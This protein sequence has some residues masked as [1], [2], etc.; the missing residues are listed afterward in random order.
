MC[1][2]ATTCKCAV[3]E[4][5]LQTCAS[6]V[7]YQT[8]TI[9]AK[10]LFCIRKSVEFLQ[11]P[12]IRLLDFWP[13]WIANVLKPMIHLIDAPADGSYRVPANGDNSWSGPFGRCGIVGESDVQLRVM[14]FFTLFRHYSR[15]SLRGDECS[16]I[17]ATCSADSLRFL[18]RSRVFFRLS[19]F[20]ET[21]WAYLCLPD[22]V[23][24]K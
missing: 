15:R 9:N 13:T 7:C 4:G 20:V 23:K 12:N 16:N 14:F 3:W 17:S 24:T 6:F 1:R 8:M 2:W 5:S 11:V 18:L 22:W 21:C 10:V 19:S